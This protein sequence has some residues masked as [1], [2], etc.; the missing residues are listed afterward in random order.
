ML[1]LPEQELLLQRHFVA[2]L[3]AVQNRGKVGPQHGAERVGAAGAANSPCGRAFISLKTLVK[4]HAAASK[5]GAGK[6]SPR[7]VSAALVQAE[8]ESKGAPNQASVKPHGKGQVPKDPG[9]AGESEGFSVA[10]FLVGSPVQGES[11]AGEG[12]RVSQAQG[13]VAAVTLEDLLGFSPPA[14]PPRV[15]A[16]AVRHLAE[17]LVENRF[18]SVY[19]FPFCM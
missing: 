6:L 15:S 3:A 5:I 10:Q 1:Q 8:R 14:P 2:V 18:R 12:G 7:E 4:P 9:V 13:V 17:M 11:G 19:P 16:K